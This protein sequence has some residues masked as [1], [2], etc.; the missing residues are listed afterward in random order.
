MAHDLPH[1]SRVVR[2]HG[3]DVKVTITW[4]SAGP[5]TIWDKLA[6]RIGRQPTNEEAA[7]EVRRILAEA[8]MPRSD[9]RGAE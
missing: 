8:R 5:H 6:A 4:H 3:C 2:R 7:A 9:A 1:C